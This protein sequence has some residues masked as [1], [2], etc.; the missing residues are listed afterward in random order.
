[1]RAIEPLRTGDPRRLG[2]YR[3]IGR[4][5]RGGQGE[6]Y[7]AEAD[8]P[9]GPTGPT[10]QRVAAK[11]LNAGSWDDERAQRMF[12]REV[13]LA[14]QVARFC[15]A[16]VVDAGMLGGQPYLIS[17]FIDG[18]SLAER[19]AKDG[20]VIGGALERLAIGTA[21]ALTA[22]HQAGIVH[23]DFKPGNVLIG[24]DGPRV[25]DF[26]IAREADATATATSQIMGT[27]AYISPEQLAGS[28]AG[29]PSDVFAWGVTIAFAA[30]GK[31]PFGQDSIPAVIN[32][33]LNDT[34]DLSP[35]QLPLRELVERCLGKDPA[36]R[37]TAQELLL[38]L[39]GG[40]SGD[41]KAAADLAPPASL[42]VTPSA[43]PAAALSPALL[44]VPPAALS[45]EPLTEPPPGPSA[46]LPTEAPAGLPAEP[47]G[48]PSGSARP[49]RRV[50]LTVVAALLVGAGAGAAAVRPWAP[51]TVSADTRTGATATTHPPTPS[52]TTPSPSATGPSA[53]GPSAIGLATTGPTTTSLTT[54]NLTTT[55]LTTTGLTGTSPATPSATPSPT[56]PVLA[57]LRQKDATSRLRQAGL[58]PGKLTPDCSTGGPPGKVL[59]AALRPGTSTVDLVMSATRARVLDARGWPL[60]AGKAAVEKA[61][62][63][64]K[65]GYRKGPDWIGKVAALSPSAGASACTG[66]EVEMS[67]GVK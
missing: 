47:S 39:L 37:P 41:L 34:P 15:T 25:I 61:G 45:A 42:S 36:T 67:I 23:R 53:T 63:T 16:Q 64:V 8:G 3:V 21:T 30:M 40:R 1:M 33:V 31:A 10:G 38:T 5:G 22:I 19:V 66:T 2:V 49:G 52:L 17:E 43:V 58:I 7:L 29:A 62:F 56:V 50:A 11:L 51:R 13:A 26:G 57:G 4:I 24:P 28:P 60:D 14:K 48:G 44:A 65:V 59:R 18:P 55:N 6:V 12:M 27:P 35:I 32:R 20:P 54:T 9:D 46:G